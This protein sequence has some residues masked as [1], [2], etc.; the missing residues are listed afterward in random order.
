MSFFGQSQYSDWKT[1]L[2]FVVVGVLMAISS[3]LYLYSTVSQKDFFDSSAPVVK[4][5]KIDRQ[6]LIQMISKVEEKQRSFDMLKTS[7]P[8]VTDPS[9]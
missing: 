1:L 5:K 4:N 9:I 7:K 8:V 3:G 6:V 2:I